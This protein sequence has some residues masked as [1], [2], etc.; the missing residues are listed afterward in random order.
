MKRCSHFPNGLRAIGGTAPAAASSCSP[1]D[2]SQPL[3]TL[4]TQYKVVFY[5]YLRTFALSVGI[6]NSLR[7]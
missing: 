6:L 4:K 2:N 3:K 5:R 7:G 1:K